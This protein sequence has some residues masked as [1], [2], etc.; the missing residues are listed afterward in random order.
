MY[1]FDVLYPSSLFHYSLQSF[2]VYFGHFKV[3]TYS[4][5]KKTEILAKLKNSREGNAPLWKQLMRL[6]RLLNRVSLLPGALYL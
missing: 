5:D 3:A 6:L 1:S 2:H 4:L